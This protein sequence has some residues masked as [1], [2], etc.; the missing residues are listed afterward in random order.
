VNHPHADWILHVRGASRFV[1]DLPAPEGTVHLAIVPSPVAHGRI[2]HL[3]ASKARDLPGVLDVFVAADIPGENQIGPMVPDE[4]LLAE[5]TVAF[6]GQPVAC[7][8]AES[9]AAAREAARCI[10]V[11]C[12][13][14][15]AI[16]D[17]REAYAHG[18]FLGPPRTLVRGDVESA[19]S[20]CATVVSGTAETGA[21]EHVYLET[22]SALALPAE[23]GVRLLA[24]T[25]GP[26]A[27]QRAVARILG[28]PMHR[29]EVE[30]PRIGGGFGGKEDQATAWAALAALAAWRLG[31]PARLVLDR[32]EDMRM[33]GKRHPYLA[34][35]RIGLASDG[36]LVA[37][38][39][40]FLQNG[41]AAA[42]LSPAILERTL[43]HA[44]GPYRIPHVRIRA[45]SCRTNLPPNTAFRG[46]GAPQAAFAMEA[47]LRKAAEASGL[48]AHVLQERNL[49][50]EGD[51]FPYGMPAEGPTARRC[52]E[53]LHTRCDVAGRRAA[54]AARNEADPRRKKGCAVMPICFGIAF[55]NTMLNQASALVHVYTDGSVGVST[56]AVEMGQGVNMKLRGIAAR[57][58]GV[59]LRR[60]K[61]EAANT[62][63]VANTSPTA[64]SS[65]ADLN[66]NAVRIACE[67]LA[68]RM[69][70]FAARELGVDPA[71][72]AWQDERFHLAGAPTAWD[73]ETIAA[74]MHAARCG[75]SALAHFATPALRFDRSTGEGRPFFYHTWGAAFVEATLDTRLGTYTVDAVRMVHDVGRSLDPR[76]DLGQAEGALA[77]GI[78][79][80][81]SEEIVFDE[82]GRLR[83][84]G[85]TTYKVPDLFAAPA[86]V[87]VV[88][89]DSENPRGLYGSKAIGEPPFLYGI[90]AYFALLEAIRAHRPDLRAEYRA[91]MT[92]ERA[93]RLLTL[94]AEAEA[95]RAP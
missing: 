16:F 94:P 64:A 14:L 57:A 18:S 28:I 41:G 77:Q 24:A 25:Q 69:R 83:T 36:R 11:E 20:Q 85:M 52:W 12:E 40:L 30:T 50:D 49:L 7:V 31:R 45:A 9:A 75:L 70:A 84:D 82:S 47:A 51:L 19:W 23:W 56:A 88:F 67:D 15:P 29:V 74:R 33:T 32:G 68:R 3:D 60:V 58:L 26:T 39:V 1:A 21:Q 61:I 79:W 6:A 10:R 59:G 27:V 38:D 42:D 92:P 8:A 89:L 63:R 87:E 13:A 80:V 5:G 65:A 95:S 46:F 34:D 76:I 91:P 54:I 86:E 48:D 71:G 90:G 17:P 73:W 81:T 93:L 22:Q 72:L 55:T 78:G 37:Y 62:T 43:L 35:F 4:P 66:G 44:T 53:A 2:V